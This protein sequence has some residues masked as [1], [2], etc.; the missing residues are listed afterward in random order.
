MAAPVLTPDRIRAVAKTLQRRR[1]EALSVAAQ[2]S[3]QQQNAA[4]ALA[5]RIM[6]ARRAKQKGTYF[7]G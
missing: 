1:T 2:P 7:G 3:T 5:E 6:A 4:R